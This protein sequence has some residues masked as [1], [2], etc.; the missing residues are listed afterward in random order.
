MKRQRRTRLP[1][2]SH[3]SVPGLSHVAWE[4]EEGAGKQALR[5]R[6]AARM[7]WA[8]P[9]LGDPGSVSDRSLRPEGTATLSLHP[10][11]SNCYFSES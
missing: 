6:A 11:A 10:T 4:P 9:F 5:A 1:P 8:A 3:T 2:W 7:P